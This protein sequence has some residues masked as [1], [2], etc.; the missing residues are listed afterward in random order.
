MPVIAGLT[1]LVMTLM[2]IEIPWEYSQPLA[3]IALVFIMVYL[4]AMGEEYG[5]RGYAL[6]RLQANWT[7]LQA[8]LILGFI[9]GAWH[10]PLHFISGTAQE[11]VP[12]WA[13]IL[14]TVLISVLM[15]W[16]FINTG[17]SILAAML[18]HWANN[19]AV[20]LFPYWQLGGADMAAQNLWTPT[21]G[22]YI[23]FGVLLAA[24]V[25]VLLLF[26]GRDLSRVP[27]GDLS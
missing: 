8:S 25:A 19:A 27:S 17:R 4:Y 12:V 15:T 18:F 1:I 14:V 20:I 16:I 7:P 22:M 23:G 21:A 6:D 2:G 5:W 9:W 3:M 11:F 26:R 10:L 24:V 13:D